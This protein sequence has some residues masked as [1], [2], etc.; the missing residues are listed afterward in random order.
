M[1]VLDMTITG[2]RAILDNMDALE[3][4]LQVDVQQKLE[5][6]GTYGLQYAENIC[7]VLTGFLRS[8]LYVEVQPGQ[9]IL[10]NDADYAA[11]VELGHHTRSGSYVPAQPFLVPAMVA[12]GDWLKSELEGLI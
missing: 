10:G 11:P 4:T 12:T 1:S 8:R 3:S 9:V 2:N 6:A 5:D 7:P